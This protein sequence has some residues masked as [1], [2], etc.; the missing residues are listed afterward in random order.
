MKKRRIKEIIVVEGVN[1]TKNLKHFLDVDTI[2][3][4]GSAISKE[5]IALIKKAQQYRGVI[6]LTDPDFPGESI[7]KI[8]MHH[9][10][11]AMHAFIPQSDALPQNKGSVG[12]EHA[13]EDAIMHALH[14]KYQPEWVKDNKI[15]LSFLR[16]M[17]LMDHPHAQKNR[18]RLS[19][20]LHIGHVNA[21]QL[22]KRLEMFDISE[23]QVEEIMT[24]IKQGEKDE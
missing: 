21:K 7:R 20:S 18:D 24:Q 15:S 6:V 19:E 2:E 1:D 11:D 12:V 8:I 16:K 14:H 3:T 17:H 10:P 13:G 5:T 9:V 23:E 4:N 22:K